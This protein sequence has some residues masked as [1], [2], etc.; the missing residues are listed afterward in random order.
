VSALA[1]LVLLSPS[2]CTDRNASEGGASHGS[3][4]G[5]ET[6]TTAPP[7]RE[8]DPALAEAATEPLAQHVDDRYP[9]SLATVLERRF[10]RVLTSRNDFDFFIHDGR[11]GGYQYEMVRAFTRFLNERHG[12]KKGEPPIQFELVPV[13]DDQLI[14]LLLEGMGDLIAARMT[15]TPERAEQVRFSRPYRSVD[16]LLVTHDGTPPVASLE[17]LSGRQVAVRATSSYADS[18]ATLDRKLAAAGRPPVD[19]VFVDESLATERILELVAAGRYPYTVA[20]SLVAELAVRIHPALHLVEGMA[21]RRDGKLAWATRPEAEA[22]V[23]E[24]NA[25]LKRYR[26]GSLLGNLAVERYFEDEG[27]LARRFSD[28]ESGLSDFDALFR[29]QAEAFHLDWRLVAA[30]AYQESHFDPT[31]HNRWGAVGLLQIKPETA[32]EPYVGIPEVAGPENASN[33]V[34]AGL[35]YLFWIKQRYFDDEPGM[36]EADRLRMALA[37]YNAGPRAVLRARSRARRAGL[38]PDRWFRNVE[39]AMLGMRKSEPVK[40]VSEIN[41]RYVSYVLLGIE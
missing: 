27:R 15:I 36:R 20:D 14:P 41:Q 25:F 18:L 38:D 40:Y 39:L 31:A 3:V 33:N 9:G 1:L 7:V 6:E 4:E 5:S 10:L 23:G 24:M 22:L 12:G 32:K 26:E 28:D 17:A 21:L 11:R 8:T 29:K 35:K 34:R 2:G 37:A 13:D 19:V 30:M 16:E